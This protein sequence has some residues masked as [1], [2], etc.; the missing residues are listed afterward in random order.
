VPGQTSTGRVRRSTKANAA[1][2]TYLGNAPA[3][4]SLCNQRFECRV[5]AP[6]CNQHACQWVPP[7][8]TLCASASECPPGPWLTPKNGVGS[9]LYACILSTPHGQILA[10]MPWSWQ[11]GCRSCRYSDT[12][13][14]LAW[15]CMMAAV[16]SGW[17]LACEYPVAVSKEHVATHFCARSVAFCAR[18]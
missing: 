2:A 17:H 7:Q 3:A 16:T 10:S 1:A 11:H 13:C 8:T 5:C 14:L 15:L 18:C 12:W 9:F 6:G 4:V